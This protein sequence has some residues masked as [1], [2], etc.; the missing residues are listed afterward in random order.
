MSD[1]GVEDDA[2]EAPAVQRTERLWAK[3]DYQNFPVERIAT[4]SLELNLEN[5]R[6]R[7]D[8][9]AL[10]AELGREL[11]LPADEE[12]VIALLLDRNCRVEQ[13]R[14]LSTLSKDTTALVTDWKERGQ[15]RPLWIE[16]GGL[17]RNGNRRLAMMKR[18]LADGGDAHFS[19]V[20]VV[21][22]DPG[23]FDDPTM[24][25]MEA[26]EQLTEGL[27]VNYTEINLLLTLQ[28]AANR[29]GVDWD[30]PRSI[31]QTATAIAPLV[32][33][34][35]NY[36][37]VQLNA[38]KYMDA[39]LGY[40]DRSEH[41]GLLRGTVEVFRDIGRNM[42][43]IEENDPE[44]SLEMLEVCFAAVTAGATYGHLREIRTIAR[45]EPERFMELAAEIREVRESAPA[46][47]EPEQPPAA[48]EQDD[49]DENDADIAPA[50]APV[51]GYPRG[52]VKRVIDLAAQMSRARRSSEPDRDLRLA[53]DHLARVP[54]EL[55]AELLTGVNGERA[56]QARDGVLEWADAVR[57]A[58]LAAP[59]A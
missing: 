33:N 29:H 14:V 54:P 51:P 23:E 22:L 35:P 56:A 5:R 9:E 7:A 21:V 38:V 6:F 36:A 19:H 4:N 10:E 26:R 31:T 40:I 17:V 48:D 24:F 43:W 28:E 30:S 18:E 15:E 11:E 52:A 46:E 59:G 25:A 39:Y 13:D 3:G 34:D 53:E 55:L 41:Y 32:G 27:K 45:E 20:D 37:R 50:G 1:V 58:E 57:A 2:G 12:I 8:R 42:K 47:L 16:P 44:R 49:E